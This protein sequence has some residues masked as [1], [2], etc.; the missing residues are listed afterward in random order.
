MQEDNWKE[1]YTD[2]HIH[3]GQTKSGKPVKITAS[4][5]LTLERIL[6]EASYKKGMEIIGVIDSHSP[7]ILLEIKELIDKGLAFEYVD[8]GVCYQNKVT[9][10]LGCELEIYDESSQGPIHILCYF[11]TLEIMKYFSQWCKQRVKNIQLSSQRIY[12]TGIELQKV[13]KGLGGWFIP[14]HV[15][16]PFKSL[17]GK[18]VHVS[19]QEVFDPALIDGIELGLS[20]DTEMGDKLIELKNYTFLSNSDAHSA[21]KIGREHQILRLAN[22]TFREIGKAIMNEDGRK[23]TKNIGLHPK[24]GKYYQTICQVCSSYVDKNNICEKGHQGQIIRGV[25]DRIMELSEKQYQLFG[26]KQAGSNNRPPYVHQV[27]LEFIPGCGSKTIEKL[28]SLFKTEMKIIHEIE[29]EELLKV[30]PKKMANQIIQAR[31]GKLSLK[32]GGGG[33][34]GKLI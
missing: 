20:S 14:A 22:P 33:T 3:I 31:L 17:Y 10:I 23:I 29:E 24:L 11:P 5:N 15:F 26:E 9:I 4:K 25:Y 32:E 18:G 7:E 30:V 13:V 2:L 16:T 19:L 21:S 28:L 1:Y 12:T 34:Y 27:P 8:G 6:E